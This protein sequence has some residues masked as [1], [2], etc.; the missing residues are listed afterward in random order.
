MLQTICTCYGWPYSKKYIYF[1]EAGCVH[2]LKWA[3]PVILILIHILPMCSLY[4]PIALKFFS[5]TGVSVLSCF[6]FYEII[7][8]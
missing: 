1:K 5:S 6:E 2:Q 3:W 4:F 7:H 8:F